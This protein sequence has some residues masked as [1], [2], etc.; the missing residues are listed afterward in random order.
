[1]ERWGVLNHGAASGTVFVQFRPVVDPVCA[2]V[3]EYCS[4]QTSRQG[5]RSGASRP[6]PTARAA[7]SAWTLLLAARR[8]AAGLQDDGVLL[9]AGPVRAA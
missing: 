5:G 7:L 6:G 8:D 1:V 3:A 2:G 4:W 9:A